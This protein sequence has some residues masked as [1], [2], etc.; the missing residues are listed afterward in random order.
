MQPPQPPNQSKPMVGFLLLHLRDPQI[1]CPSSPSSP[2]SPEIRKLAEDLE[3]TLNS[4]VALSQEKAW[5]YRQDW[6]PLRDRGSQS[7]GF[8]QEVSWNLNKVTGVLVDVWVR[9]FGTK[10]LRDAWFQ[11]TVSPF[12]VGVVFRPNPTQH[13][14][15]PSKDPMRKTNTKVEDYQEEARISRQTSSS[16]PPALPSLCLRPKAKRRTRP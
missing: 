2:P 8:S 10:V 1:A 9:S 4:Y 5:A 16:L 15:W 7:E 13:H 3:G 12:F 6:D 11:M 14:I